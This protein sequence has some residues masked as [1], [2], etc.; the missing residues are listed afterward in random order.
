MAVL[1]HRQHSL[2]FFLNHRTTGKDTEIDEGEKLK[3][4]A[5]RPDSGGLGP[6]DT[7]LSDLLVSP[8]LPELLGLGHLLLL[9]LDLQR[10]RSPVGAAPAPTWSSPRDPSTACWPQR[11][12]AQS[13]PDQSLWGDRLRPGGP[14]CITCPGLTRPP[15]PPTSFLDCALPATQGSHPALGSASSQDHPGA[16][17]GSGH[18]CVYLGL[19][20]LHQ[21]LKGPGSGPKA[22]EGRGWDVGQD[23]SGH[24]VLS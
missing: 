18:I 5:S 1:T 22:A 16:P 3:P 12:P 8:C 24:A 9:R 2:Y 4:A 13:V 23:F 15:A 21:F 17:V 19:Q 7:H 14:K 10:K 6:Q 11:P 20:A